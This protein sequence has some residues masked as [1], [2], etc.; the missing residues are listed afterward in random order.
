MKPPFWFS[1]QSLL[2]YSPRC[3]IDWWE[4]GQSERCIIVWLSYVHRPFGVGYD[5]KWKLVSH[6]V[7]KIPA[8]NLGC[9]LPHKYDMK[10]KFRCGN[11]LGLIVFFFYDFQG[12][13][14][15]FWRG[16]D[17]QTVWSWASGHVKWLLL[18]VC[19]LCVKLSRPKI[20]SKYMY[21]LKNVHLLTKESSLRK[22]LSK[23]RSS[24]E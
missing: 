19:V 15:Q 20:F 17:Q 4:V 24:Q 14:M 11:N 13:V 22:G 16:N 8:W 7:W 12:E 9:F 1:I 18:V 6:V 10:W 3:W 23:W 5:S 21:T 2:R